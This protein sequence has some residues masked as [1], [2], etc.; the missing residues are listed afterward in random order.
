MSI[1]NQ[2]LNLY[3]SQK[4]YQA[5]QKAIYFS[6]SSS[7]RYQGKKLV[8]TTYHHV[9]AADQQEMFYFILTHVNGNQELAK[10]LLNHCAAGAGSPPT[11]GGLLGS[12]AGTALF[13]WCAI[14]SP[15]Y[16]IA[17]WAVTAFIGIGAFGTLLTMYSD[18][19]FK[20]VFDS[21]SREPGGMLRVLEEFARMM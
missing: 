1:S 15:D 3:R 20:R 8:T 4:W 17:I 16:Q 7:S 5:V 21:R 9:G 19:A 2:E 12:M 18:S 10:A 13:T 6:S 11:F 14:T